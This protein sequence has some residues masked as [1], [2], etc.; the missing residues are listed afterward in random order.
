MLFERSAQ[1]NVL[2]VQTDSLRGPLDINQGMK[3]DLGSTAKLRTLVYYLELVGLL[4]DDRQIRNPGVKAPQDPISAWIAEALRLNPQLSLE[5][6]LQ[7]ALDRTYSASPYEAFFT[8]GGRHTFANFD[9]KDNDRRMT[10]RE[11][12]YRSTNLLYPSDAG[13]GALPYSAFAV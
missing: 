4:Y 9:S 5:E 12:T 2:R 6:L 7:R 1:G 10:V 3:M 11:A 8:G 13:P